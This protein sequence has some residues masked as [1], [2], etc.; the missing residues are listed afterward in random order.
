MSQKL[1]FLSKS[2]SF[3]T[4]TL[5]LFS[6]DGLTWSTRKD[7]LQAI[8]DRHDMEKV[9]AAQ[10]KGEAG[11]SGSP[12]TAKPTKRL[13]TQKYPQ[14]P[15]ANGEAPNAE[16]RPFVPQRAASSVEKPLETK[17]AA[18]KPAPKAKVAPKARPSE[19]PKGRKKAG[20]K[21]KR[22]AA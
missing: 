16:K 6:L 15:A 22:A 8:K 17:A 9:T 5:K 3:G 19:A 18:K 21:S 10:L 2:V 13:F 4:K 14:Q 12:A 11:E 1:K 20:A 7:E